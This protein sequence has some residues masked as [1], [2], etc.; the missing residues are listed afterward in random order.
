MTGAQ[1]ARQVGVAHS[2]LSEIENGK[3]TAELGK[4]L[5]VMLFLGLKI[6]IAFPGADHLASGAVL[7]D[8]DY[9]DLDDL[10]D[11]GLKP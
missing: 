9:P 4:I 5:Q 7:K 1:L 2:W 10:I 8:V 11:R 3:P 6:D